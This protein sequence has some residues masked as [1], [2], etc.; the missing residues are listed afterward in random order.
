M[1]SILAKIFQ[2]AIL[3]VDMHSVRSVFHMRMRNSY[4]FTLLCVLEDAITTFHF[5]VCL[6]EFP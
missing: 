2:L 5:S 1:A 6:L 4:V 3:P